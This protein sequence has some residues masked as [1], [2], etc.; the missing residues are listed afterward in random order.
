[1][2]YH[3]RYEDMTEAERAE[4]FRYFTIELPPGVTTWHDVPGYGA[5][6][7][8]DTLRGS[9]EIQVAMERR[10]AAERDAADTERRASA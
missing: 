3:W 2:R 5:C 1:M 10:I 4:R 6:T 8:P 9:A 7:D